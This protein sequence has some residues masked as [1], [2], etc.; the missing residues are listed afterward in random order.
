MGLYLVTQEDK[1]AKKKWMV[2]AW[3]FNN[4]GICCIYDYTPISRRILDFH[5]FKVYNKILN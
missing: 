5:F 1:K 4:M 3:N 2:D